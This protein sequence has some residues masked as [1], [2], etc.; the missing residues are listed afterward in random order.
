MLLALARARSVDVDEAVA[1]IEQVDVD[2][3]PFGLRPAGRSCGPSPASAPVRS[4]D[5]EA[6]EVTR[7]A[8]Y[9]DLA[10][11][12]ARRGAGAPAGLGDDERRPALARAARR[13]GVVGR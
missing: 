12:P 3:F 6:V 2:D 4:S 13:A 9:F 10:L 5:A 1:A 11:G 8:S 7:G